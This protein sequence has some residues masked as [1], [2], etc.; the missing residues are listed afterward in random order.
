MFAKIGTFILTQARSTHLKDYHASRVEFYAILMRSHRLK[1][2][3]TNL[4]LG[5]GGELDMN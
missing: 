2:S 5:G 1:Q 3:V 4:K